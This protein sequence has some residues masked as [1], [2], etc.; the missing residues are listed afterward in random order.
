MEP[1]LT[2][3]K[4][5]FDIITSEMDRIEI[6]L[7]ELL[8]LAKPQ[9]MKFVKGDIGQILESVKTLIDTQA[10]MNNIE[11]ISLYETNIF[12]IFCDVNQLKQ[13]FIN[14]LKN[15]IEAMPDGG[16]ITIE[17]RSHGFDKLKLLF[18]DEGS[19]IPDHLLNRIYEPFFTTKEKGTGLGL[20]ISKQIIENHNGTLHLL[21][22]KKGTTVEV[23]LPLY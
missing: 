2:D 20:M 4:A 7:S 22:D 9:D 12:S 1:K 23:I 15:S 3:G 19:G 8:T 14:F 5:Y 17:L 18:I 21:S 11:I 10:L 13:V 6:I 16:K